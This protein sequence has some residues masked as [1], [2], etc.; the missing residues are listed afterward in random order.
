MYKETNNTIAEM[1]GTTLKVTH[2]DKSYKYQIYRIVNQTVETK[3]R[4]I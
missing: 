3:Q 4:W 1:K 2:D